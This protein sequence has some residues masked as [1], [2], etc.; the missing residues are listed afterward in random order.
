MGAAPGDGGSSQDGAAPRPSCASL[1]RIDGSTAISRVGPSARAT[2]PDLAAGAGGVMAT[3][4]SSGQVVVRPAFVDATSPPERI[5]DDGEGSS[6]LGPR[7][8][9]VTDGYRVVWSENGTGIDDVQGTLMAL[10]GSE[11]Q[12][13]DKTTLFEGQGIH[14]DVS[15]AGDGHVLV[16]LETYEEDTG[17]THRVLLVDSV[18]TVLHDVPLPSDTGTLPNS[19]HVAPLD[20]G[21]IVARAE[22]VSSGTSMRLRVQLL[23]ADLGLRGEPTVVLS[24][25][26]TAEYRMSTLEGGGETALLAILRQTGSGA[27]V[28]AR[29]IHAEGGELRVGSVTTLPVHLPGGF[30][31]AVD[32]SRSGAGFWLTAVNGGGLDAWFLGPED[33]APPEALR[34]ATLSEMGGISSAGADDGSLVVAWSSRANEFDRSR[35]VQ[36]VRYGCAE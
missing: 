13:I 5:V 26:S 19:L 14:R 10:V 2:E 36:T 23:D 16:G 35:I 27:V 30:G 22:T 32:V 6:L 12:V 28:E 34:V 33:A 17:S 21:V 31:R 20:D 1:P 24:D 9:S 11:G 25:I 29:R 4:L 7:I 15:S 3:W 18:G 8:V